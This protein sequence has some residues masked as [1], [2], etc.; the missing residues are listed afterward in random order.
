MNT[1]YV[2]RVA[3]LIP[4]RINQSCFFGAGIQNLPTGGQKVVLNEL[5]DHTLTVKVSMKRGESGSLGRREASVHNPSLPP[6]CRKALLLF[7]GGREDD[8]GELM[9]SAGQATPRNMSALSN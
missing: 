1:S 9:E 7:Q 4:H 3:P 5:Q 2:L 6:T 8:M